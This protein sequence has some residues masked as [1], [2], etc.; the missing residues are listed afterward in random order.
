MKKALRIPRFFLISLISLSILFIL[1]LLWL[2]QIHAKSIKIEQELENRITEVQSLQSTNKMSLTSAQVASL[3][4]Q[5]DE[6]K[7]N[8]QNLLDLLD[9]AKEPE[10]NLSPLEFKEEL[11]KTRQLLRERAGIWNITIPSAI[12]F[13]EFEGGNIPTPQDVPKLILQL[14][15]IQSLIDYAL[16]SRV[17]EIVRI[18]KNDIQDI[19]LTSDQ[20]MYQILP[21]E[22][23]LK[24]SMQ[25]LLGFLN[26]L[27][28]STHFFIIRKMNIESLKE[29]ILSIELEIDTIKLRKDQN[30]KQSS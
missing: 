3:K 29:G 7:K 17:D 27:Y 25:S 18:D 11:L 5:H 6:V 13:S 23:S 24:G 10:Q 4:T 2:R 22:L 30:E 15:A 9:T 16:E 21:F 28:A 26:K 19:I 8:Y 1:G 12:G 20:M 14:D